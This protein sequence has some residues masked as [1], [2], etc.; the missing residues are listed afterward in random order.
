MTH[1]PSKTKRRLSLALAFSVLSGYIDTL[2]LMVVGGA[3]L[4]FMSGNTTRLGVH[5]VHQ[6]WAMVWE[7]LLIIGGFVIGAGIGHLIISLSKHEALL[8]VL[9][10][11]CLCFMGALLLLV[12][13]YADYAYLPFPLAMGFQNN[14]QL[15]IGDV[16]IGKS[17]MSGLL[18]ALGVALSKVI[19]KKDSFKHVF[20]LTLS[21]CSFLGGAILGALVLYTLNSFYAVLYAFLFVLCGFIFIFWLEYKEKAF[22]IKA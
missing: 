9:G 15:P 3:F 19:Q 11:D 8:W 13:P 7:Y 14:V 16:I 2:G 10:F 5:L 20:W 4:S 22:V 17:F 6:E 1:L 21:W 18:F 12:S